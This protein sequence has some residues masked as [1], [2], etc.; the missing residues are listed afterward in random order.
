MK[1]WP[2]KPLG[3]FIEERTERLRENSA[4]IY[5]VTNDSGFVRSLDLFDKQVFSADTS[6]YKCVGFC[7]LAYNPSRINVGSVAMLAD[8][9]GGAVSPMYVIVRCKPGLLPLYLLQ[10]LKSD[11]GQQQIRHRCEGTVRFQLKFRDLCAIPIPVPPLAE[12]KRIIKLLDEADALRKLRAA[13]DRRAADL[14][15]ALFHEMFGVP[16]ANSLPYPVK[17][18]GDL[19][20]QSDKINYGVVQPGDEV[21]DGIPIIRAG[22]F[23]GMSI[24]RQHLKR[25]SPELEKN[26]SRSRLRGDEI[27]ISCVGSIGYVALADSSLAGFNI[28]RAVARVPLREEIDRVFVANQLMTPELQNFFRQETRTVAQPTLNIRQIEETPIILPPL[29]LQ[30]EFAQRVGEIRELEAGQVAS[31]QRLDDLFQSMLHRAFAGEL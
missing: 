19:V 10:F 17:K 22:D 25:I 4:T 30:K 5:S 11:A 14:I 31:R 28:V 3:E 15:P 6:N 26:Y 9:G 29:A 8:E 23:N 1:N 24:D 13:T 2:A 27:L 12:Q 20:R 16:L 18:M 7:D 21:P